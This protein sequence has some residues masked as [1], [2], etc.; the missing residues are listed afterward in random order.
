M[1]MNSRTLPWRA[2]PWHLKIIRMLSYLV[3]AILSSS[4]FYAGAIY[5]HGVSQPQ[6]KVGDFTERYVL[7]GKVHYLTEPQ[8]NKYELSRSVAMFSFP[9]VVV[10]FLLYNVLERRLKS[11]TEIK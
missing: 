2:I 10:L 6:Y 9:V 7:K 4:M 3:W 11:G 1:A 8:A 5:T